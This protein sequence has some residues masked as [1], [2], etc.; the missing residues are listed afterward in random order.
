MDCVMDNNHTAISTEGPG[1]SEEV[2]NWLQLPHDVLSLI[3]L[4]LGVID[5]LFRA[6]SVCSLWRIFFQ[7]SSAVSLYRHAENLG[8]VRWSGEL[9]CL[10]IVSSYQVNSDALVNMAKKAVMLEEL[11]L[12]HCS[13]SGDKIDVLK[14]VGNIFPHL[15]SFRLNC[16][17]YRRHIE[18][19][20]EALVIAENMPELRHLHLFGNKLTNVGLR[21]I[22]DGCPHL[23]SL[24]LRQCFN[25]DLE[26]DLMKIC[27]DRLIK[28]R[29]PNDSTDDYEFDA[30]I[31]EDS[32]EFSDGC[33]TSYS[34]HD[35]EFDYRREFDF[36]RYNGSD[37][38]DS[39]NELPYYSG[40]Y[41]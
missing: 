3:F 9:R 34:R 31:D 16:Q 18:C 41:D 6:Q 30:V 28:L 21:S 23:E 32:D 4:K 20:D 37:S 26:G 40:I 19:D 17:G 25:L 36:L 22:F 2:R 12:S 38:D 10:R 33:Y 35:D 29:L 24:D 1:S 11:E 14:T 13:F 15:K 27:R 7:R 8:S 39:R 5:I